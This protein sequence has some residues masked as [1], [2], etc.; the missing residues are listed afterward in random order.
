MSL[1]LR[2]KINIPIVFALAVLV[3]VGVV[4]YRSVTRLDESARWVGHTHEVLGTIEAVKAN[5]EDAK[6]SQRGYVISGSDDFLRPYALAKQ[7]VLK[8]LADVRRLT[9]DNPGQQNRL[10]ALASLVEA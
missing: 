6:S 7:N 8:M 9:Y 1:S 3:V 2:N 5:I 4:S 10:D